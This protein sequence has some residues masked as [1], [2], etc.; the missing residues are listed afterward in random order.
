[1]VLEF[2]YVVTLIYASMKGITWCMYIWSPLTQNV[3]S[4]S[5]D[6]RITNR[7]TGN[8]FI[9]KMKLY[10]KHEMFKLAS[11]ILYSLSYLES[12]SS[13]IKFIKSSFN[14]LIKFLASEKSKY[15]L[16]WELSWSKQKKYFLLRQWFHKTCWGSN[17]KSTFSWILM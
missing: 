2:Y 5:E 8:E 4:S 3:I 17:N 16:L 10:R 14:R 1:M 11:S 6:Y 13:A 9:L 15:Y 7:I 12:L